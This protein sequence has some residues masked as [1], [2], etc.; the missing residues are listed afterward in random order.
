MPPLPDRSKV[1]KRLVLQVGSLGSELE[2]P[3]SSLGI[4]DGFIGDEQSEEN[5]Q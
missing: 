2:I 4:R 5:G 1:K 3:T